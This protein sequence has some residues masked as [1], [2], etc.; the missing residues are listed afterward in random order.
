[1]FE[2]VAAQNMAHG[3]NL[4]VVNFTYIG[5]RIQEQEQYYGAPV[6]KYSHFF[7]QCRN[8]RHILNMYI[9]RILSK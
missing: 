2:G 5:D 9:Y 7:I 4:T 3:V 1:M 6:D 8:N